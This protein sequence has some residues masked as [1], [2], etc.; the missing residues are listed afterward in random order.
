MP[1]LTWALNDLVPTLVGVCYRPP[2]LQD[3]YESDL[4]SQLRLAARP[5]N[6]IMGDSYPDIDWAGRT[7]FKAHHF[8][9]ALQDNF[10]CQ[11]VYAP[12]RNNAL[13]DLLI[14]NNQISLQM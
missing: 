1:S 10:M 5:G 2:N 3:D 4:L 11:L 13:L 8:L 9:N 14:S 12:A 7:S 6:V